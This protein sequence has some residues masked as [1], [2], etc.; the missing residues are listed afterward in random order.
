METFLQQVL[1]ILTTSPGNLTYHLVLTFSIAVALQAAFNTW[2]TGGLPQGRRMVIG[3]GLLLL[4][5]IFLFLLT[6]LTWQVSLNLPALLLPI[7]DRSITALGLVIIVWLW[8]FPD[9]LR[10]AD[11]AA[12][13]FCLSVFALTLFSL[14]WLSNQPAPEAG[15]NGT[16]LDRIWEMV[17]VFLVAIGCLLLLIR[18]PNGWG[19]GLVMLSLLLLGHLAQLFIPLLRSDYPA[20]VRLFQLAAFPILLILSQRFSVYQPVELPTSVHEG[21]IHPQTSTPAAVGADAGFFF[22][23]FDLLLDPAQ[24]ANDLVISQAIARAMQADL[25]LLVSPPD[26]NDRV[27]LRSGYDLIKQASLG[28]QVI[29]GKRAARL[30][31]ALRQGRS[32]RI[33]ADHAANDLPGLTQTLQLAQPGPV[34]SAAVAS[35]GVEMLF[36]VV[37]L[38]PSN[39]RDWTSTDE[40]RLLAITQAL[41]QFFSRTQQVAELDNQLATAR[42]EL[43]E[44]QDKQQVQGAGARAA[45][46]QTQAK[47][48]AEQEVSGADLNR[49]RAENSRLTQALA[50]AESR[51]AGLKVASDEIQELEGELRLAL[52]EIARL[53]SLV[54]TGAPEKPTGTGQPAEIQARSAA[55]LASPDS[56]QQEVIASM[57]QDLRQPITSIIGYADLLLSE[58][59]GI[60]GALQ[61]KFLERIRVSAERIGALIEDLVRITTLEM[62]KPVLEW[63]TVDLNTVIDEAISTTAGRLREKNISLQVDMPDG[64]PQIYADHDAL[65]QVLINLLQNAGA[66]T[67]AEGKISLRGRVELGDDQLDYV[68]LQVSD[69]GGGIPS[70]ELPRVFT[71]LYRADNPLIQGIGDTG[72][73]LSIVKTLVEAHEGRVWVDSELG[74]GSTFSILLPV[75]APANK[76]GGSGRPVA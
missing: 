55:A 31:T 30:V 25:C 8:V 62:G 49:L 13:L 2:R 27:Q 52:E 42:K 54:A 74:K 26:L 76:N 34:L 28:N 29:D 67:P 59:V 56:E 60:V 37:L 70:D 44:Q 46:V 20:A 73:G 40:A 35:R 5:R 16:W 4:L 48:I 72:V 33:S 63:G 61:R 64:L 58:S 43:R 75:S 17:A 19:V 39:G 12:I 22:Q 18:R 9:S 6:G 69:Q 38:R 21:L 11:G 53:H 23:I 36:G 68:F 24:P 65:Q 14:A 51:A 1:T 15:F 50:E 45:N 7:L 71:R 10:L 47:W 3:L 66:A 41:G 57:T 32:L